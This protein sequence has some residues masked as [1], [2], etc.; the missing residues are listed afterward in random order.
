VVQASTNASVGLARSHGTPEDEPLPDLDAIG[1]REHPDAVRWDKTAGDHRRDTGLP[2]PAS[3]TAAEETADRATAE[4]ETAGELCWGLR[5]TP[6]AH[7]DF[8]HS[9]EIPHAHDAEK[10][11]ADRRERMQQNQ[12]TVSPDLSRD[13]KGMGLGL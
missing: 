1:S 8:R 7:N 3:L 11:F 13:E 2:A 9:V 4:A 5:E 12:Q 10:A 6:G